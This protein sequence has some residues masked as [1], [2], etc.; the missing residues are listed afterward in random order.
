MG[1]KAL[2]AQTA[3]NLAIHGESG[4]TSAFHSTGSRVACYTT[5]PANNIVLW[6]S[7]TFAADGTDYWTTVVKVF[8]EGVG[9]TS[10]LTVDTTSDGY[11]VNVPRNTTHAA[12]SLI[13]GD[14]LV[15]TSTP[16]G[17]PDAMPGLAAFLPGPT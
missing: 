5:I 14:V 16:S 17:S 6:P 15:M 13:P 8:R 9:P 4:H 7:S 1:D 3:Q 11:A 12:F 10:V 2:L